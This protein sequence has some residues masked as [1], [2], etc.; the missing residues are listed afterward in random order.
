ML[1]QRL[2]RE[3]LYDAAAVIAAPRSSVD[4]GRYSDAGD[5]T[6]LRTFASALAGH[7]A[8]EAARLR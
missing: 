7:I 2:A 4:D 1:C 6:G 8:A 5:A 3:G